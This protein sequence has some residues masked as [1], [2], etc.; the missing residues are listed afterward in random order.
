M[1]S[2]RCRHPATQKLLGHRHHP[3]PIG[4]KGFV[5]K[6]QIDEVIATPQRFDFFTHPRRLQTRPAPLEDKGIGA[7]RAAKEAAGGQDV[8]E[9][10]LA[11]Q[12]EIAL[13]RQKPIIVRWQAVHVAHRPRGVAYDLSIGPFR[14]AGD[15]VR[16]SLGD[17]VGQ[18]F[19]KLDEGLFPL[20]LHR[21]V[22]A[23]FI[24]RFFREKRR[25]PATPDHR[26]V[27]T[28]GLDQARNL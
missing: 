7:K 20:A 22:D 11:L 24:K 12:L 2:S 9:L 16:F 27:R 10:A 19:D 25:M 17:A 1:W 13:D 26:E 3:L 23:G 18:T 21:D 6:R 15:Q 28:P 4:E 5:L 14:R 8:V